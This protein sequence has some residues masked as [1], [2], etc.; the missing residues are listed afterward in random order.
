LKK[1]CIENGKWLSVGFTGGNIIK[2]AYN[3]YNNDII[4]ID[5]GRNINLWDDRS[6]SIKCSYKQE[7]KTNKICL[8]ENNLI[9]CGV[10]CEKSHMIKRFDVRKLENVVQSYE[11]PLKSE[12]SSICPVG[13]ERILIGSIEGKIAMDYFTID[14][15]NKVSLQQNYSFKC[16]REETETESISYAVNAIAYNQK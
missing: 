8:N 5:T 7:I 12:V 13:S 14:D 11:N 3:E 9:L 4:T 10:N 6:K 2:I 16:H 1:I 15:I